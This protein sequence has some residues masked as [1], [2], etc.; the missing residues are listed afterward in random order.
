MNELFKLKYEKQKART[1]SRNYMQEVGSVRGTRDV[2]C[3]SVW[4]VVD[5]Q[6]A[7]RL[8]LHVDDLVSCRHRT[9]QRQ[10]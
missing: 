6:H 5:V 7:T 4:V 3:Y 10:T 9:T 8:V 1:L 2:V